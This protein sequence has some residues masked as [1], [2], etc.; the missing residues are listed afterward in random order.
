M[1]VKVLKAFPQAVMHMTM[2]KEFTQ[3]ELDFIMSQHNVLLE[4]MGNNS[5]EDMD[6]LRHEPLANLKKFVQRCLDMYFLHVYQPRTPKHVR[7]TLTQSWLNFTK[8]GE[9]HHIHTHPN[10]IIS[11]CLYISAKREEDMITFQ[12]RE[13]PQF[14]IETTKINDFNS[15]ELN[16]SVATKDIVLFPSSML[17]RV[18]E[19][20]NKDIRISLA[21]NSFFRGKIGNVDTSGVNYLEIN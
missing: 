8:E 13:I 15:L 12:K 19:T 5:S 9:H 1:Q 6:I 20:T 16:V 14:Q 3:T 18:P 17:H 7:L 21:F 4:N 11:G 2:D 10:S